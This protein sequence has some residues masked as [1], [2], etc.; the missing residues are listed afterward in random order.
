[1]RQSMIRARVNCNVQLRALA[2]PAGS[3]MCF[4][5]AVGEEHHGKAVIVFPCHSQGGNQVAICTHQHAI[6]CLH[7]HFRSCV[8]SSA[9]LSLTFRFVLSCETGDNA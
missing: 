4:D 9:L 2:T 5:S 8:Q 1:M 6:C 3:R 7:A